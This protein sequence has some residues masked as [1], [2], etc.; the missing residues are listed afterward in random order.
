MDQRV[1]CLFLALKGLST[2]AIHGE[3]GAVLGL[4]AVAYSTVTKYFRKGRLPCTLLEPLEEPAI[5][6]I[7]DAILSALEKQPF[8]SIRELA[9]LTCIPATTVYRP[10]TH[11]L[12]FIVK[13][14]RWVP[15]SLSA[16]QKAQR[17][18]LANQLLLELRSIKHHGWHFVVTLDESWFYFATDHEQI[19]MIPE[20]EPPARSRR[21]I[22]DRRIMVTVAWSPLGF[23]IVKALPRGGSFDAEYSRD[24]ILAPSIRP[25]AD[26]RKLCIH[27]DNARAHAVQKNP[28]LF[29]TKIS[30]GSLT[31]TPTPLIL[32]PVISFYLAMRNT[33]SVESYFNRPM[34]C[35][36]QL[37]VSSVTSRWTLYPAS[38]STGWKVSNG[39]RR[40]KMTIIHELNI[41]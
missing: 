30:C 18:T 9:N 28:E 22:Q 21:M 20:E 35:L 16:T 11:S 27:A 36:T 24:N 41:R 14:L 2:R 10:L 40:T 33:L 34:S 38:L 26:G 4:D 3:L 7:D 1:I 12:G 5:A 29:V 17:V 25:G 6:M 39:C 15:H 37:P 13:H 8:S 23:H 31:I 19:W 32:H